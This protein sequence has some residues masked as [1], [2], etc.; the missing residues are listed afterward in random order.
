MSKILTLTEGNGSPSLM[1]S[2]SSRLHFECL[3]SL[4]SFDSKG[5]ITSD[6]Y[7]SQEIGNRS[8]HSIL[9]TKVVPNPV[10]V[11]TLSSFKVLF[12]KPIQSHYLIDY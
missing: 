3:V 6:V 5:N 1:A 7:K 2:T 9:H 11:P 8:L 10:S 12:K 4:T